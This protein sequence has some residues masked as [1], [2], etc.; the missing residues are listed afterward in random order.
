MHVEAP[1]K[2]NQDIFDTG[3]MVFYGTDDGFQD[4]SFGEMRELEAFYDQLP[5]ARKQNLHYASAIGGLYGLNLIPLIRPTAITFFDINPHAVAY[6]E[7]IRKVLV[8]SPSKQ[9]FLDRLG[10]ADYDVA[11]PAE[12]LIRENIALKQQGR[13]PRERGSSKRSFEASWRYALDRYDLT[14]GLL[15]DGVV[16]VRT[17]GMQSPSFKDFVRDQQNFWLYSSNIF[18]FVYFDLRFNRA[19]NVVAL[20]IIYPGQVD[21]LD[22]DAFSAYPL[23]LKCQIPM[24]VTRI[25]EFELVVGEDTKKRN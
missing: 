5:A 20:S 1:S 15:A 3:H 10:H 24:Q 19:K 9:A 4:G 18:E 2:I 7:I 25:R 21:L 6:F 13:L 12:E 14:R 16:Q 22:L 8:G 17:E 23:D 11:T